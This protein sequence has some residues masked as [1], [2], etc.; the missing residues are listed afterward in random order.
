MFNNI[1]KLLCLY[2]S[3]G[4]NNLISTDLK[5]AQ[6]NPFFISLQKDIDQI[7]QLNKLIRK[8]TTLI[9]DFFAVINTLYNA[10]IVYSPE[11]QGKLNNIEKKIFAP[12]YQRDLMEN[13]ITP[14]LKQFQFKVIKELEQCFQ[15]LIKQF[16]L[17][18]LQPKRIFTHH[19]PKGTALYNS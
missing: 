3:M 13:N 17:N 1:Y 5:Y 16:E 12:E 7:K 14:N 2:F 15:H 9:E 4:D 19:K 8:D 6:W 10:H 11:L 18:G